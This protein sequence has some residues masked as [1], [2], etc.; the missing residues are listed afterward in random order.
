M[1][2]C[3]A[4]HKSL[5]S[6]APVP[7]PATTSL[8]SSPL[9]SPFNRTVMYGRSVSPSKKIGM[10]ASNSPGQSGQKDIFTVRASPG[11]NS[12]LSG[13]I[14]KVGLLAAAD[15]T[16]AVVMVL[17]L[18]PG[19][20]DPPAIIPGNIPDVSASQLQKKKKKKKKKKEKKKESE[21]SVSGELAVKTQ[22]AKDR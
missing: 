14:V 13:D 7:P 15:T 18:V 2:T 9:T 8:C 1:S 21:G 11:S 17:P 12:P 4:L 6:P 19:L 10:S 22:V 3:H 20:L 5:R 16:L